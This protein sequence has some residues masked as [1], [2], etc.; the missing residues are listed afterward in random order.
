VINTIKR[1]VNKIPQRAE[2][3]L[4]PRDQKPETEDT[5]AG[6]RSFKL[7]RIKTMK[8]NLAIRKNSPEE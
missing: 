8:K 6:P 3:P 4:N 5:E 1:K 7:E 2:D